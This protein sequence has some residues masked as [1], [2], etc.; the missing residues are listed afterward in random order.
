MHNSPVRA[1]LVFG[2]ALIDDFPDQKIVGGAP[3]NVARVSACFGCAPLVITRVGSDANAQLVRNEMQRFDLDQRGVQTDLLHS[4]GLVRVHVEAPAHRFEILADQAYD[5]INTQQAE[6]AVHDYLSV[7]ASPGRPALMYFGTLAQRKKTSRNTLLGLLTASS[8][9]NYL[10]LNLR[11]GHYTQDEIFTSLLHA[12]I[13]KVND[14]EMQILIKKFNPGYG[15]P[16]FRLRDL[17]DCRRLFEA[18]EHLLIL[19]KL[20][21]IIVTLGAHGYLYANEQGL[22]HNGYQAKPKPITIVDT[23]GCGD[24]FSSIFLA[25]LAND[26]PLAVT[27]QRAHAFAGAVCTIRGAVSNDMNFYLDWQKT[28]SGS[29]STDV[30]IGPP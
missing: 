21:A 10:D 27:L 23:V 12:D 9:I 6:L 13:L 5:Y 7:Q 22:Q 20:S 29:N 16:D 4:T 28:W 19:F 17:N 30:L 8:G 15:A 24:A 26:W 25:G 3:F 2:E 11:D 14:D 1:L 18:M